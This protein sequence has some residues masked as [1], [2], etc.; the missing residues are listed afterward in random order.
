MRV[1]R[2]CRKEKSLKDYPKSGLYYADGRPKYKYYCKNCVKIEKRERYAKDKEFRE[3][4]K[5]NSKK[6]YFRNWKKANERR[7]RWMKENKSKLRAYMEK[8][9]QKA[10]VEDKDYYKKQRARDA[11]RYA[12]KK[13][14][15]PRGGNCY[16]CDE[17]LEVLEYHHWKGY[18]EKHK[19]D[20]IGLCSKC[21][22]RYD[23]HSKQNRKNNKAHQGV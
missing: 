5:S 16:R 21:H 12:K 8:W 17:F 1:C 15:I 18:N 2:T 6:S 23:K 4:L 19:L 9:R 7:D 22:K 13:G 11:V 20:V 10:K 14:E 3:R